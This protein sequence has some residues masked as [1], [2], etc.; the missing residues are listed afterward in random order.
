MKQDKCRI[1][2]CTEEEPCPEGCYRIESNL[3]SE[4]GCACGN[5]LK[6]QNEKTAKLCR[7]CYV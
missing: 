5:I 7:R 3:C 4:C 2:K 1:C 6:T